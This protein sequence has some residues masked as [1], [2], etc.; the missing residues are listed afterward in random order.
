MSKI[1]II[2]L[3]IPKHLRYMLY[4]LGFF[5]LAGIVY[6]GITLTTFEWTKINFLLDPEEVSIHWYEVIISQ[7]PFLFMVVVL[8]FLSKQIF[9]K[10][11][12]LVS[13]K[14]FKGATTL[15]FYIIVTL[16][17]SL[18]YLDVPIPTEDNL[19][20]LIWGPL[21]MVV[22]AFSKVYRAF[23]DFANFHG[24]FFL[25]LLCY[26]YTRLLAQVI[27]FLSGEI[28]YMIVNVII[29][30]SYIVELAS[31]FV[32]AI[33]LIKTTYSTDE[34]RIITPSSEHVKYL[35]MLEENKN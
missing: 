22:V 35:P 34:F 5:V 29:W 11:T 4:S 10:K 7:L 33:G 17:C 24:A 23:K 21:I 31:L 30:I 14:L 2:T 19:S 18:I 16:L 6:D 15:I 27:I 13:K 3:K 28:R 20:L 32:F 8:L 9:S 25:S 1:S 26:A 12:S